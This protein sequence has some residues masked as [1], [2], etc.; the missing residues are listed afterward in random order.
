MTTEDPIY[1]PECGATLL[2]SG[3]CIYCPV[4]GWTVC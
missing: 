3:R 1:C 2:R 4:C